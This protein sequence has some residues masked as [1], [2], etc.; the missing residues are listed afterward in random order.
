[1]EPHENAQ[2]R[3]LAG[4]QKALWATAWGFERATELVYEL[5]RAELAILRSG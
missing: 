5:A 1:M 2:Q 4:P 3:R